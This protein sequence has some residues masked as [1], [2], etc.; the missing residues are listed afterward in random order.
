MPNLKSLVY[1][2]DSILLGWIVRIL[3]PKY[4]RRFGYRLNFKILTGYA[5][6][7]KTISRH[8]FVPWPVHYTSVVLGYKNIVKGNN[9]DPG[10]NISNYIQAYNGVIFG[11]NVEIGPGVKII[12]A[13]HDVDDMLNI[14]VGGPIVIGSNV[15]IGANAIILPM[16]TIGDNTIIGA[17][18]VVANSIPSNVIAV[19]NPCRVIKQ[20]SRP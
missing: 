2:I 11:D 6:F 4:K 7:Q 19:G 10:D 13:N 16:V 15:W 1:H 14:S 3:Y 5:L 18:S 12:S 8:R 20:N 17:G 9:C